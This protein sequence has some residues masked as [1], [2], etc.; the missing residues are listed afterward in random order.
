MKRSDVVVSTGPIMV[1]ALAGRS[2]GSPISQNGTNSVH[3][4][5]E[6]FTA[7]DISLQEI[8]VSPQSKYL[9]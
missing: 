5:Q 7:R 4:L 6:T 8:E 9:S 1:N 2:M 3:V